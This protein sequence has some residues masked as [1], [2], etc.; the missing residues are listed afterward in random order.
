ME[1]EIVQNEKAKV[2]V[3]LDTEDLMRVR[4]TVD[5]DAVLAR[6][7]ENGDLELLRADAKTVIGYAV[8]ADERNAKL[9]VIITSGE[10]V[11]VNVFS[12]KKGKFI[13]IDAKAEDGVLDLRQLIAKP[14][15]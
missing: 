14:K 9:K 10:E 2:L 11:Q 3:F 8:V 5:Y 12:K 4:G 15:K 1:N 13:P 7:G 6:V